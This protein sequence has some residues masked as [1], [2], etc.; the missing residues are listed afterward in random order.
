MYKDNIHK[1]WSPE[2]YFVWMVS[3]TFVKWINIIEFIINISAQ[4]YRIVKY[5]SIIIIRSFNH[6]GN[7]STKTVLPHLMPDVQYVYIQ[8]FAMCL[9]DL[10]LYVHSTIFQL[11]RTGVPGL[12][13]Y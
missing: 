7:N 6:D 9:F 1:I 11:C 5:V 2:I 13:Q 10:I 3:Q 8:K 4:F 12:N